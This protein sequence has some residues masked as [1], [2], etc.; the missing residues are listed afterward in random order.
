VYA[1]ATVGAVAFA[2]FQKLK[3][4][5]MAVIEW[6]KLTPRPFMQRDKGRA[7]LDI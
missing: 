7:V 6:L 5:N 3:F 1:G 4:T 2:F